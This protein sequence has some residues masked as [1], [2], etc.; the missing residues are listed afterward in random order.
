M[1]QAVSFL[2]DFKLGHYMKIPPRSMFIV[3][4][5]TLTVVKTNPNLAC[6]CCVTSDIAVHFQLVGTLIASTINMLTAWYMLNHVPYICQ[7]DSLPA[8]SPWTCRGDHVFYDASVIWGLV[9]PKR[10]FGPLGNY[11]ALN[12]FFLGGAIAPVLVWLLHK[13]FPK[14][15]WI[16]LINIPVLLGATAGMPPANVLNFNS[17]IFVGIVFN[18]FIFR[19]R[20]KWW[21]RYNYVLSAALDVGLAFMVVFIYLFFGLTNHDNINWWG[22]VEDYCTLADCPTAKGIGHEGCH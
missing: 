19:Y 8:G 20:K 5:I 12:W 7:L 1:S 13:A 11:G 2:Q 18:F 15:T 10:F 14:Q 4:V 21:Q 16:K 3:Q 22:N 6:F 17:W 9:G